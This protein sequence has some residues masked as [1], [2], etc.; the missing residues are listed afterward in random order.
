MPCAAYRLQG[1]MSVDSFGFEQWRTRI[2]EINLNGLGFRNLGI[3]QTAKSE[4]GYIQPLD[5]E[6]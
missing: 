5:S 4:R 3:A 6:L 1:A 2:K